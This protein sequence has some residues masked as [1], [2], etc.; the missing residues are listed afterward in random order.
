MGAESNWLIDNV[1]FRVALNV[2]AFAVWLT[3]AVALLTL[4]GA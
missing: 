1:S 4:T 2:I 3:A